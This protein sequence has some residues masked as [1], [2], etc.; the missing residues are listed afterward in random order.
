LSN[1]TSHGSNYFLENSLE[2]KVNASRPSHAIKITIPS[3]GVLQPRQVKQVQ[4]PAPSRVQPSR[5]NRSNRLA[6][7]MANM[8]DDDDSRTTAPPS[9]RRK[10]Q[11]IESD[12]EDAFNVPEEIECNP[13]APAMKRR[14]QLTNVENPPC[15]IP[16]PLSLQPTSPAQVPPNFQPNP[17]PRPAPRSQIHPQQQSTSG[18]PPR[19]RQPQESQPQSLP[20]ATSN[21]STA[22]RSQFRPQQPQE[23]QPQ[24]LP[25]VTSNP[26]TAPRSQFRPQQ[27]RE[28]QPQS[29]PTAMSNPSNPSGIPDEDDPMQE[30]YEG[31]C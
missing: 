23:S 25:T 26:S 19:P 17:K 20:T 15:S 31:R 6:D 24:S 2:S 21:P 4:A 29:L 27:P 30:D 10:R 18:S 16:P 1:S 8:E 3:S 9:R 11:V 13:M 7:I 5:I 28:S 22:P 14:R 12:P